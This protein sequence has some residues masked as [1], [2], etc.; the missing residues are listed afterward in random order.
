VFPNNVQ[1]L[2]SNVLPH[3]LVRVMDEIH[4]SWQGVEKPAPKDLSV[5]LSVRPRVVERALG[6][7]KRNNP[8]YA[9]IQINT[10]EMES[11][12]ALPHG[13]PSQVYDRLERNEPS[14]WEKTRTAQLVPPTERGL[15]EGKD[16]D[17]REVLALL[18]QEQDV[19]ID[20]SGAR[21]VE[22]ERLESSAT[23]QEISSSGM[24]ALDGQPDVADADK[25][26]YV[27]DALGQDASSAE[28]HGN[29]WVGT[30]EVRRGEGLEPYVLM[31]RGDGFA[32][33]N[34]VRFF[35]KAFPTLFPVGDWGPRQ[36]EE[37]MAERGYG[38]L[39]WRCRR[40]KHGGQHLNESEPERG[41]M[42]TLAAPAPWWPLRESPRFRLSRL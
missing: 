24:F 21:I 34:E 15:E 11:W 37:G 42:G 18:N 33:S 16:V 6:W 29:S 27:C 35:A 39:V 9:N 23:I 1:E 31:S 13:V 12:G 40:R 4:V 10:A 22:G 20:E 36:A 38:R 3:P 14:A 26:Q 19:E 25:L 7:L 2:A 17:V 8:L 28:R 5:L 41:E 32:D 30:A